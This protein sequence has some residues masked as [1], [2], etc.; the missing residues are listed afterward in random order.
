MSDWCRKCFSE[1]KAW[2]CLEV[3]GSSVP[4]CPECGHPKPDESTGDYMDP[5]EL[6]EVK[7]TEPKGDLPP[8]RELTGYLEEEDIWPPEDDEDLLT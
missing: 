6:E 8:E 4:W 5:R 1:V 3:F 7:E 2:V